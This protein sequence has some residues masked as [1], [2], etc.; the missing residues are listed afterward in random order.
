MLFFPMLQAQMKIVSEPALTEKRELASKPSLSL[1]T[2]WSF[3]EKYEDYYNDHFGLRNLFIEWN[4]I[5]KVKIYPEPISPDPRVIIG[6]NGWLFY[7]PEKGSDGI[8]ISDFWGH[9]KYTDADLKLIKDNI[10]RT[11]AAA[12]Q[13]NLPFVL[14]IA[15]NKETI[16]P[17]YLPQWIQ[18]K[19]G[20]SRLDQ[21]LDYLKTT[22]DNSILDV[23]D[24]LKR[25]KKIN[26]THFKTDTHWNQF[27]VFWAYQRIMTRLSRKNPEMMP[28]PFNDFEFTAKDRNG[29]DLAVMIGLENRLKDVEI[30]FKL[31]NSERKKTKFNKVVIFCDSFGELL[32]DF[33]KLH[34]NNIIICKNIDL[35]VLRNEKPDAAILELV[36]RYQGGLVSG[37][38]I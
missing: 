27:G 30:S 15:P 9:L 25:K 37:G 16:Y 11:C 22:G 8:T 14:V 38:W 5:I 28:Y 2:I 17:E 6:K 13:L 31:K 12:D 23:R 24:L 33:L 21:L 26:F 29:G 18:K 20:R 7:D 19:Q 10:H 4:G 35:D 34:F 3:P 36:E 32:S 1:K